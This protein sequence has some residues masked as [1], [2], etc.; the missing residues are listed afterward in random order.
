MSYDNDFIYTFNEYYPFERYIVKEPKKINYLF[1]DVVL[2]EIFIP[3][4]EIKPLVDVEGIFH[5]FTKICNDDIYVKLKCGNAE[6]RMAYFD[7]DEHIREDIRRI[8]V[9]DFGCCEW[10]SLYVEYDEDDND[11]SLKNALMEQY[12]L[13]NTKYGNCKIKDSFII[14]DII[15]LLK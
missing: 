8:I 9:E 3:S 2:T 15:K 4:T 14:E 6:F 5:G 10:E 1:D 12:N 7:F 13:I 11:D